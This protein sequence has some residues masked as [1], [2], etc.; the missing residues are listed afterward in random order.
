MGTT[1]CGNGWD[2]DRYLW[3]RSGIGTA[4]VRTVGDI[5]KYL[6]PCSS[7]VQSTC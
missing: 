5:S 7:L 3:E 6:C 4:H 2:G 1:A